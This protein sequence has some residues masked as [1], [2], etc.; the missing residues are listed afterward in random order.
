MELDISKKKH[1]AQ[2]LNNVDEKER[3]DKVRAYEEKHGVKI[4]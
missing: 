2:I 4:L 1:G 3:L